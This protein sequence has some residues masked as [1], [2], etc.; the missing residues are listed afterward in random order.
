MHRIWLDFETYYDK[1][2]SLRQMTP[3]EYIL[4]PRFEAIG[5]AFK[6]GPAGK[7]FWVDG[8]DLPRF[9]SRL[10]AEV[11]L[12]SH[13][14]L[15]DMCIVAW[16]YGFKP[17]LMACTLSIARAVLGH[18]LRS[19]S[20]ENVAAH[21]K[22][23]TKGKAIL[24]MQGVRYADLKANPLLY[25]EF[26]DYALQDVTLCHAIFE[27]LVESGEFPMSELLILD[28]VIRAATEPSF[29]LDQQVL[30]D[31]LQEVRT[32]KAELLTTAVLMAGADY[33]NDAHKILMS[34]EKFAS[35]LRELGVEP[36]TKISASTGKE[37]Y[38]FAKSDLGFLALEE[39]ENPAVQALYAARVGHKSTLEETRTERLI[40]ISQ[41]TWPG[42]QRFMP[43]PVRFSGAHTH[44]LSGDWKLNMQNLPRGSKLRRALIAPPGHKV[45][46][47]DSAQVE[48]RIVAW[49]CAA[50][51]LVGQFARGED[52]YSSFA[53]LVFGFPVNK[54]EHP[55]E[56]FV[57]KQGVLGLGFG[58]GHINFQKRIKIDSKNQ[59]GNMIELSDEE[60]KR[61]VDTY[62]N[63]YVEVPASWKHLQYHG[64]PVLAR[65]GHYEFGPVKFEERRIRLPNGLYLNYY[66]LHQE[67]GEWVF[68]YAG[69]P[70]RLYGGKVLENIVQ[71]LARIITM[72]ASVRIRRRLKAFAL[73]AHDE[74]GFVV[75]DERVEE[76]RCILLE[77]MIRRPRWAPEL[78]LAAEVGVGQSYGD[79][80]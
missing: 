77:E 56:R 63:T 79:A 54:K 69:A 28:N 55:T 35:M 42:N 68:E 38:A 2:Y 60:A 51:D 80:K 64:I 10:P 39:H 52:V 31:H 72:D 12:I 5:C 17:K 15:F 50:W 19:L 71:A 9:F 41:L 62:R 25:H 73:Q 3:V 43:F 36:P 29:L 67:A 7:P 48:A 61:V 32:K 40:S 44:R 8:P 11:M 76:A 58:L 53:S 70:K 57:G 14:A 45:I 26:V 34:N 1:D 6:I 66:N 16:R 74:L 46:T 22:L 13:N 20:L 24:K 78:P 21:L 23:G 75:P 65:G 49:I 27:R 59:T 47:V 18:L 4:D 33:A 30:L 37:T